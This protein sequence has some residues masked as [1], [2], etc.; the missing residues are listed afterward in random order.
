MVIQGAVI[1]YSLGN[2]IVKEVISSKVF[3]QTI[4]LDT[5]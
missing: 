3:L 2:V 1:K 4:T 5:Y